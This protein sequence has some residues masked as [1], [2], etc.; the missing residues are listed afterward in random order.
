MDYL[1]IRELYHHQRLGAKHGDKNG[2][3]YPLHADQISAK[4]KSLDPTVY[5]DDK[6][7]ELSKTEK[8]RQT[9]RKRD[10]DDYSKSDESQNHDDI[11]KHLSDK[12]GELSKEDYKT[13]ERYKGYAQNEKRKQNE[14]AKQIEKRQ[15]NGDDYS[16][17]AAK[18][19]ESQR[20]AKEYMLQA[21]DIYT[22]ANYKFESSGK[23]Y[24]DKEYENIRLF[25]LYRVNKT[26]DQH[27]VD[28][29]K[30]QQKAKEKAKQNTRR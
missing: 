22:K 3:P 24:V 23:D 8:K 9:Y 20:L 5:A 16:E 10:F 1:K 15:L 17:L 28:Y 2:P 14:M 7:E 13:L 19:N 25:E 27:M 29:K 4:E 18:Y 26:I 12:H 30:R 11:K 6:S 21:A